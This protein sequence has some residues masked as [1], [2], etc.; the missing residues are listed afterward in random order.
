[1]NRGYKECEKCGREVKGEH[2]RRLW[3]NGKF[4]YY[5]VKCKNE[6]MFGEKIIRR[7]YNK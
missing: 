1:M 4:V 5:C 7:G 3:I 6:L 2:I